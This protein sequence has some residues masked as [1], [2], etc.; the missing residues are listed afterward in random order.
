RLDDPDL[1]RDAQGPLTRSVAQ[2]A[3]LVHHDETLMAALSV[4]TGSQDV[5]LVPALTSLVTD[6]AVPCQAAHR[7]KEPGIVKFREWQQIWGLQRREDAGER[8]DIPVPPKY[9]QSDF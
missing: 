8:V 3:D 2:L 1:W 7:Y 9:K 6:E 4:L 5:D